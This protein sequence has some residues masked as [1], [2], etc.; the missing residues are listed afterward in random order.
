MF[1]FDNTSGGERTVRN[2]T[3]IANISWK[4]TMRWA[5]QNYFSK[6]QR[7]KGLSYRTLDYKRASVFA[8]VT[9]DIQ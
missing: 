7:V 4:D 5:T 8:Y 1:V 9:A 6:L 2:R 3:A